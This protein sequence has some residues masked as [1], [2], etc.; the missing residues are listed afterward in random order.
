VE[1][2]LDFVRNLG[3]VVLRIQRQQFPGQ[4]ERVIK[5]S[6]FVLSLSNEFMLEFLEKLQ[7][8]QILISQGLN[9]RKVTSSP[10]TAFMAAVSLAAA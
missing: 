7:V 6:G 1:L 3:K 10:I 8:S 4:S 9:R 2:V 5:I